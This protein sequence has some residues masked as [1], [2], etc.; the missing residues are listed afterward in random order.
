MEHAAGHESQLMASV[1]SALPGTATDD[2]IES[3]ICVMLVLEY[4]QKHRLE[5]V[6]TVATHD[7]IATKTVMAINRCCSQHGKIAQPI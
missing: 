7:C 1:C 3:I 2:L 4:I 5:H 6:D